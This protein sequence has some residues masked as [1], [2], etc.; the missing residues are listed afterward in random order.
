ML[1]NSF[2]AIVL[3]AILGL[4]VAGCPGLLGGP[5]EEEGITTGDIKGNVID[6]PTGDP[7]EG[8]DI[9]TEPETNDTKTDSKG[10]YVIADIDPGTYAVIASKDGY[11]SATKNVEVEAGEDTIS[12]IELTP[13]VT[14][15]ASIKRHLSSKKHHP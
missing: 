15:V 9:T 6:A 14:S 12:D 10:D 1:K 7:I 3:S 13:E 5:G 4:V 11:N 2:V 8:A